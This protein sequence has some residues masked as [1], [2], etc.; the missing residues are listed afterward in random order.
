MQE[1]RGRTAIPCSARAR[2]RQWPCADF[3]RRREVPLASNERRNYHKCENFRAIRQPKEN[4]Q[5][6]AKSPALRQTPANRQDPPLESVSKRQLPRVFYFLKL[7]DTSSTHLLFYPSKGLESNILTLI[8]NRK[9]ERIVRIFS[10]GWSVP[11]QNP[12]ITFSSRNT[13]EEDS[14]NDPIFLTKQED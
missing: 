7:F 14:I 2:L 12:L 8:T 3:A 4:P 1:S 10:I 9:Q 5:G 6:R 13:C 11:S